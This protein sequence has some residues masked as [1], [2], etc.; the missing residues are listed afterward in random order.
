M[1]HTVTASRLA[2]TL[3]STLL[4][5]ASGLRGE[6][7]TA[8]A[9]PQREPAPAV[10]RQTTFGPVVGSDLSAASG[11]YA[12]KGVPFAKPPIGERRWKAPADPDAW[13]APRLTQQ[14]GPACSQVGRLYGP[15]QHNTYDAT[16]GTSL[17]QTVGAL[18]AFARTGNP[19]NATL[20]VKW[21]TWPSTLVFDAT[22][23]AKAISLLP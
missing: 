2:V 8:W 21:P 10:Q 1:T 23:T 18:G 12:W 4:L 16:I 20:G 13:T 17:G 22:P 5:A 3:L 6:W 19:N 11:A 9:V 15:G 14:F 7:S